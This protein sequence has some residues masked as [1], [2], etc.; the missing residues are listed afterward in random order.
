MF[1][2]ANEVRQC[3]RYAAVMDACRT[4]GEAKVLDYTHAETK[5]LY[6]DMK[7]SVDTQ[8]MPEE[9]VLVC[10]RGR[11]TVYIASWLCNSCERV[12]EYDGAA[13]GLFVSTRGGVY[14]RTFVDAVLELCVIACSMMAAASES[15]TSLLRN[16]AAL[17][18]NEPRK[19]RQLLSDACGEFSSTLVIPETTFR[20]HHCGVEERMGGRFRCVIC[21]GQVLSVLQDHVVEMLRPGMK[22]PRVDMSLVIAC[23]ILH[24]KVRRLVRN[25]VRAAVEDETALTTAEATAWRIFELARLSARPMGAVRP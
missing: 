11:L 21:D 12:V 6:C 22:A 3:D 24:A 16:T 7:W 19:A 2:C 9:V 13:N 18:E 14:A 15:L 17:S 23:A 5:C 1:P 10:I 20:C 25:R 8:V 4:A